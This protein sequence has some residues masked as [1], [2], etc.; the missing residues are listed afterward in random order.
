MH[1]PHISSFATIS[2]PIVF[3]LFRCVGS[4]KDVPVIMVGGLTEVPVKPLLRDC[5]ALTSIGGVSSTSLVAKLSRSGLVCN[6]PANTD[7]LKHLPLDAFINRTACSIRPFAVVYVY[8]DPSLATASLYRRQF[9]IPHCKSLRTCH[10]NLSSNIESYASSN[11]D[12]FGFREH[13]LSYLNTP[14]PFDIVFFRPSARDTVKDSDLFALSN[15]LVPPYLKPYSEVYEVLLASVLDAFNSTLNT[16]DPKERQDKYTTDPVFPKLQAFYR[17]L[18]EEW[19]EKLPN[20]LTLV[21]R[22]VKV[23]AQC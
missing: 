15:I 7:G 5:F 13:M 11:V 23:E 9:Q 17:P 10:S 4:W 1:Q 6:H 19:L 2:F 18:W 3:Y 14:A 16:Y 12:V 22:D 21:R 20:G 8:D